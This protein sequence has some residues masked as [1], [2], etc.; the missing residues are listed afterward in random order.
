MNTTR[1]CLVLHNHQPVGNFEGVI[2]QA[3]QDSYLPFLDVFEQY[4]GINLSL[5]TSGP[6]LE[7]LDANH[8]DYLDRLA[9]LVAVGRL[10]IIG[11]AFY[12]PILTMLPSRDRIGQI[13]TYRAWLEHR[14]EARVRGMWLPE[15]VWEQSLTRDLVDAG[16]EY[17]VLDDL[18]FR[19]AGMTNEQLDGAFLTDD[20]GRIMRLFPGSERLRYLIPFA[21]PGETIGYL[22][23]LHETHPNAVAVF[24]DDGEKFGTWPDTKAHVYEHG[25]L[26]QFFDALLENQSWLRTCTLAEAADECPPRGRVYI[27]DGSYREMTEWVLPV[28]RHAEYLEVVHAHEHDANWESLR[29][30]LRGGYWRNFRVRYSEANEMYCRMLLVSQRLDRLAKAGQQGDLWE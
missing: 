16:V 27:P 22:R 28:E 4:S 19:N 1:F 14:L 29:R 21:S 25:W 15:R 6:L 17:A 10:E 13:Q 24:G 8:P 2:E 18:H 11:G 7:W 23:Q 3:Y 12:E 5:H 30:F 20:D 26:R 9:A